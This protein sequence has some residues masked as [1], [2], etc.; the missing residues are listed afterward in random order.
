MYIYK[1]YIIQMYLFYI[2]IYILYIF[3][4]K[5]LKVELRRPSNL[6]LSRL[7]FITLKYFKI[8]ASLSA[9]RAKRPSLV[10]TLVQL[11]HRAGSSSGKWDSEYRG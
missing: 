3:H 10:R 6:T 11:Y 5:I 8:T 1:R 9:S 2:Y 4:L 7:E